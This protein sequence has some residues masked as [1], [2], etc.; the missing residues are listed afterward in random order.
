MEDIRIDNDKLNND[1]KKDLPEVPRLEDGSIDLEKISTGKDEKGNYIL[2]DEIIEKYFKELPNGTTNAN[3][4]KWVYSG[5]IL[6]KATQEVR[7][8]GGEALR[9]KVEQRKKLEQTIDYL[10]QKKASLKD[11][12]GLEDDLPEGVDKQTAGVA[13]MIDRWVRTGDKDIFIALRDTVGEKP[14]DKI[15][16]DVTALTPEDREMIERV[17]KRLE[18]E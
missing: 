5:G 16:A 1:I 11:L 12:E 3:N 10:L 13:R 7:E 15:S 17:S 4:D 9:A 6:R 18:T 2:P 8:K 14:T